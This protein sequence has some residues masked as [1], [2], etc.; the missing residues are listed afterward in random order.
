MELFEGGLEGVGVV[1]EGEE[2]FVG[3]RGE[4]VKEGGICG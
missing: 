3:G 2:V 1:F 4:K